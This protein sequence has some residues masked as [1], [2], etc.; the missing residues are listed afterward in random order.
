MNPFFGRGAST[1]GLSEKD[2]TPS[3]LPSRRNSPA[4]AVGM[5]GAGMGIGAGLSGQVSSR[6]S[7]RKRGRGGS[8]AGTPSMREHLPRE[9]LRT[10][11]FEAPSVPSNT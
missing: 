10:P 8:R 11:S 6:G 5:E 2:F 4:P 1:P 9:Y 7:V 3:P